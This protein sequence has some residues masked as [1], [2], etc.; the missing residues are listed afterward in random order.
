MNTDRGEHLPNLRPGRR[1]PD[2]SEHLPRQRRG[3]T[4]QMIGRFPDFDVLDEDIV[5]TWD[6][7][8][9]EVVMSRLEQSG[10]LRFFAAHEEPTARAFMDTV[11]AQDREPRVPIVE[12][13][14]RKYAEGRLDGFH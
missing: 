8:T 5:R 10:E 9:R 11:T 13:V 2:P 14:D 7:V 6:E 3:V 12:L 1:P 4:P